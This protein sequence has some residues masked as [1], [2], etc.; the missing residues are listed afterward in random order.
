MNT[1][2]GAFLFA[3][4]ERLRHSEYVVCVF[5]GKKNCVW[6][7]FSAFSVFIYHFSAVRITFTT[8][9]YWRIYGKSWWICDTFKFKFAALNSQMSI[10]FDF[11]FYH[12]FFFSFFWH[13]IKKM[14]INKQ[15]KKKTTTTIDR[16]RIYC[17]TI[18]QRRPIYFRF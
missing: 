8:C 6:T 9:V 12:L 4:T 1:H 7:F 14:Y 16:R 18:F 15:I 3:S 11:L 2:N 13:S 5:S 10:A 17:K